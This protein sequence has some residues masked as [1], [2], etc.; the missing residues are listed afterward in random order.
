[1]LATDCYFFQKPPLKLAG[2]MGKVVCYK[3]RYVRRSYVKN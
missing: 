3:K 2:E 1:M